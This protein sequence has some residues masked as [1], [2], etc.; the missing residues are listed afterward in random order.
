VGF[1]PWFFQTDFND[2]NELGFFSLQKYH[3]WGIFFFLE[4]RIDRHPQKV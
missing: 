2:F 3:S 1:E 4:V